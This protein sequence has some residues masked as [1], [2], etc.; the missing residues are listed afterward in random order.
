MSQE[1]RRGFQLGIFRDGE[2][3]LGELP[4]GQ[5]RKLTGPEIDS[6]G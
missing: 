1:T 5:W 6:L 3:R 2:L 4:K